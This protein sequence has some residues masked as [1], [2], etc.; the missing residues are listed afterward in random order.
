MPHVSADQ[1]GL[2]SM[3][4]SSQVGLLHQLAALLTCEPD[5]N[6]I[7]ETVR[8]VRSEGDEMRGLSPAWGQTLPGE[9][10]GRM[11]RHLRADYFACAWNGPANLEGSER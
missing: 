3:D 8:I 1:L 11:P 7:V 10:G 5:P 2:Y 6:R 9:D 4:P